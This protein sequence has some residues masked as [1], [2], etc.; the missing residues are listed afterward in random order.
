MDGTGVSA[1]VTIEGLWTLR[2]VSQQRAGMLMQ[3]GELTENQL[4]TTPSPRPL[5]HLASRR[6]TDTSLVTS[7]AEDSSVENLVST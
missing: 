6:V 7:S 5:P 3:R 4:W 1:K 2:N